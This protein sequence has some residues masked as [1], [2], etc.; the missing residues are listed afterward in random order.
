MIL[1][2]FVAIAAVVV[3]AA[4]SGVG[5]TTVGGVVV[6][7]AGE[8]VIGASV[9]ILDDLHQST[10]TNVDGKFSFSDVPYNS[11]LSVS[12]IG[13]V[14]QEVA[15][16][17][18]KTDYLITLRPDNS[19]LDEVVVVGYATQKKVDLTGAVSSVN[20]RAFENRPITNA[21]NALAGLAAGLAVSNTGGNTPGYESQ[22][23]TVRGLGTL[24]DAAPLVVVDG[25]TG[26]ALS[27]INPQ[28]IEY[29]SVLKRCLV[30][31]DIRFACGKRG[32]TRNHTHRQ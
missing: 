10:V 28:D 24:N 27:D 3:Q 13:F 20:V 12:Y 21:A 29:I 22:S 32:Y 19:L 7:N 17:P 16:M 2:S 11:R 18:G 31:C 5:K 6:D 25:M 15:V 4:D 1:M 26:I 14:S 23:I 8:P 9:K 30:G